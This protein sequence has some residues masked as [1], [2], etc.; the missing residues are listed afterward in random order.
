MSIMRIF[1]FNEQVQQ[2]KVE[3]INRADLDVLLKLFG[4]NVFGVTFVKKNG[5]PRRMI[6]RR[7]V[8]KFIKGSGR[9]YIERPDNTLRLVWEPRNGYRFINLETV[10]EFRFRGVIYKVR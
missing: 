9:P 1:E 3:Y 10:S 7:G 8:K 5:K 2:P 4:S 6:A